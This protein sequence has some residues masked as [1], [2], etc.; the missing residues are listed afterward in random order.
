[1]ATNGTEITMTSRFQFF[2]LLCLLT[3]CGNQSGGSSTPASAQFS[4][5]PIRPIVEVA[6]EIHIPGYVDF[7]EVY[8]DNSIW[9]MNP[10][11]DAVELITVDGVVASVEVPQPLG[12]MTL[13]FG[14][15]WIASEDWTQLVRI[16]PVARQIVARVDVSIVDY[17][18]T[19]AAA[20]GMIWIMTDSAGTLAY[21]DPKSNTVAGTVEVRT[22]SF[23]VAAGFGSVWVSNKGPYDETQLASVQRI[24]ASSKQVVATIS[25]GTAPLFL[26]AGEG[27]VWVINQGDGTVSRVDPESN[28]VVATIPLGVDGPGGDI[29]T[30][31]GHVWVRADKTLLSVIDAESNAVIARYG[32][33]AGSGGVR[34]GHGSV[35]LSAHDKEQILRIPCEPGG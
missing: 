22:N 31:F 28:S 25:V 15:L 24:D 16:D 4:K 18:S 11:T 34:A 5:V 14:S 30:G 17:E 26:T 3:A 21:V 33:Q 29:S 13:A 1:M 7:L 2:V 9:V 23:G 27:A 32:P 8:D 19:L 20:G 35:W 12:A 10:G 6:E